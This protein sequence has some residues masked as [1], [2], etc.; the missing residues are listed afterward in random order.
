MNV[1]LLRRTQAE[2]A[3]PDLPFSWAAWQHCIAGY[4]L[5]LVGG[6]LF[7]NGEYAT[8]TV[9]SVAKRILDLNDEQVWILFYRYRPEDVSNKQL[10]IQRI[11]E[12]IQ[13]HLK[14]QQ[15]KE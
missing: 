7:V 8:Q 11:E 5:K 10:A 14:Q 6:S 2:I 15:P 4:A 13:D 9:E 1:E 3:R 12:V